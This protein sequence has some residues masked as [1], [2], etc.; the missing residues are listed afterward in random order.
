P[1]LRQLRFGSGCQE[2]D[3]TRIAT[4]PG[5]ANLLSLSLAGAY[6]LSEADLDAL[7]SARWPKLVSLDL[8]TRALSDHAVAT[9]SRSPVLSRVRVL[10]LPGHLGKGALVALGE[11]P[12]LGNLTRLHVEQGD[13]PPTEA[14]VSA[15]LH[16]TCLPNLAYI[17]WPLTTAG[18][19]VRQAVYAN[20]RVAWEGSPDSSTL[21]EEET[22]EH[23]ARRLAP[24]ALAPDEF[25]VFFPW[26]SAE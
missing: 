6:W 15:L 25:D 9:L 16:S 26:S 17:K 11:S 1:Q 22:G 5:L 14:A 3:I 4:C 13:E 24:P 7:Q 8:R 2:G 19:R 20:R 21:G 23:M 18:D 12:Y 10:H